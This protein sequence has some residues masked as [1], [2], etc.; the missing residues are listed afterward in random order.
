MHE[1]FGFCQ[2]IEFDGLDDTPDAE[3]IGFKSQIQ[4]ERTLVPNF[5]RDLTEVALIPLNMQWGRYVLTSPRS[6]REV[7]QSVCFK[8]L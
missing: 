4:K 2:N 3:D 7:A 1:L 6:Q 8:T 5:C